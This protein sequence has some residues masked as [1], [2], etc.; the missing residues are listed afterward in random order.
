MM[1]FIF[2]TIPCLG[3]SKKYCVK[4]LVSTNPFTNKAKWDMKIMAFGGSEEVHN[5]CK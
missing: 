4:K 3:C 1:H 2:T 5:A